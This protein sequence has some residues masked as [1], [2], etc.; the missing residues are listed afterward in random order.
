MAQSP[1]A[2]ATAPAAAKAKTSRV[3]YSQGEPQQRLTKAV[4]DWD[5]KTGTFLEEDDISMSRFCQLVGIPKGT[6]AQYVCED[7]GKRKVIGCG[8]GPKS[9]KLDADSQQ[10]VVD[11]VRRRDRAN[12]GMS[13]QQGIDMVQDLKP[14][15]KRQQAARVFDR[16]VRAKNTDVL[17]GIVKANKSTE[18]RCAITVTQQFRWHQVHSSFLA[19]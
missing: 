11:V 4:Y 14:S 1:G 7:K 2:A 6:F 9:L 12:D 5:N 3:N 17:T 16:Q 13:R 10:F 8:V 19:C 15:L 18:K